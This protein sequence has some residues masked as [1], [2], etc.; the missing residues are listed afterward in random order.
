MYFIILFLISD[1]SDSAEIT[2]FEIAH[3]LCILV[4]AGKF[5]VSVQEIPPSSLLEDY[6]R[7]SASILIFCF[8]IKFSV[9]STASFFVEVLNT[10]IILQQ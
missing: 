3:V 5:N 6:N 9:H 4:L 1:E 8:L 7:A 10:Y 2:H